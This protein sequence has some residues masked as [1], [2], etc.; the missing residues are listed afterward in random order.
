MSI[1]IFVPIDST[2][3]SLGANEVAAAI[4]KE[5][6][7]RKLDIQIIRNSSRGLFWLETLVEVETHQGRIGFGPVN[8]SDVKSLFD[9]EFINGG[10]HPLAL[11][12]VAEIDWLKKQE[13]LTFCTH[14]YHRAHQY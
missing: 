6:Q 9:A 1:K 7:G 5:A 10:K 12:L 3:L 2:A 13:R 11:G 4:L 14:G 8:Q